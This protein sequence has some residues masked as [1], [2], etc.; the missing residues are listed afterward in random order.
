MYVLHLRLITS[1]NLFKF[2]AVDGW[3]DIH[4]CSVRL[5]RSLARHSLGA[6]ACAATVPRAGVAALA[7]MMVALARRNLAASTRP[8]R[9]SSLE[10]Y[11]VSGV[12]GNEMQPRDMPSRVAASPPENV[13]SLSV[14]DKVS[15]EKRVRTRAAICRSSQEEAQRMRK[16]SSRRVHLLRSH[17]IAVHSDT[18]G[19]MLVES[20]SIS[21]ASE[22]L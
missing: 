5:S 3:I 22:I 18:A 13:I 12:Q 14:G 11:H 21:Y 6:R 1:R 20:Y 17:S 9:T 16:C 8:S 7:A 10:Q 15:C 2:P 4:Q 19:K